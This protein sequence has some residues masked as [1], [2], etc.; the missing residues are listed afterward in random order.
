MSA[1]G[2]GR[3]VASWKARRRRRWTLRY[4]CVGVGCCYWNCAARNGG[5]LPSSCISQ[6]IDGG[7]RLRRAGLSVHIRTCCVLLCP[8]LV[9]RLEATSPTFMDVQAT[10][11]VHGTSLATDKLAEDFC[12]ST[13]RSVSVPRSTMLSSNIGVHTDEIT[14]TNAMM[15]RHV[16]GVSYLICQYVIIR[17]SRRRVRRL[18]LRSEDLQ[19]A[20][21]RIA[22][23][24]VQQLLH[25]SSDLEQ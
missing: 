8:C 4:C 25:H 10:T 5:R 11:A 14:R 21:K 23:I 2:C 1:F 15:T 13:G 9:A 20:C 16:N 17:E 22:H 19:I 7:R 6:S 18:V 3:T 24:L 12:G